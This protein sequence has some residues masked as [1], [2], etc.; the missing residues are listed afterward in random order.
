M[1][2]FF[3]S[4]KKE[5]YKTLNQLK[6]DI[7]FLLSHKKRIV[8]KAICSYVAANYADCFFDTK[9]YGQVIKM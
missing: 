2:K 9:S 4:P 5:K 8:R 3:F 1:E 6:K 7:N